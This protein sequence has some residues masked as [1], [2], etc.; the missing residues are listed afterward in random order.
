[1]TSSPS[2]SRP[3]GHPSG[4]LDHISVSGKE[5][6]LILRRAGFA[7]TQAADLIGRSEKV[8][9]NRLRDREGWVE[10][11]LVAL[12]R[13]K[14]GSYLWDAALHEVRTGEHYD[15]LHVTGKDLQSLFDLTGITQTAFARSIGRS[16]AFVTDLK[17]RHFLTAIPLRYAYAMQQLVGG[18][19]IFAA[20]LDRIRSQRSGHGAAP[21]PQDDTTGGALR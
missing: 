1:M 17:Y 11:R 12:L 16:H 9:A 13:E 5:L 10:T 4:P 14:V 7:I 20:L 21:P 2:E 8:I 3:E 15:P 6:G 19:E 18:G